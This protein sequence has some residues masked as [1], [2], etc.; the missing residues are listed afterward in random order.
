MISKS[1]QKQAN[2]I[3]ISSPCSV[4]WESMSGDEKIRFCGECKKNVHNIT[5][6]PPE[7]VADVLSRRLDER[8]CVFMYRKDNGTVVLDNCPAF[9]RQ[10]RDK[11]RAYAV[12]ALLIFSWMLATGADAQGLVG[13]PIDPRYGQANEVGQLADF[14]YDTARNI[15]LAVTMITTVI[16]FFFPFTR[17]HKSKWRTSV[18][19]WLALAAIPF[20][21]HMAGTFMINNI[22]GLGGGF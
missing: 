15:S 9:L 4:R 22:G 5:N 6:M 2:D 19:H 11:I 20:L 21:V 14:G 16:V 12:A 17:P 7:Q 13:A 3:V 1:L 18:S 10:K 8:L